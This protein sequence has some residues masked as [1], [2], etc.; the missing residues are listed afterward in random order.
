[1]SQKKEQYEEGQFGGIND[2]I[3]DKNYKYKEQNNKMI[4]ILFILIIAIIIIG[5]FFLFI[6][7]RKND[8]IIYDIK[9]NAEIVT[10]FFKDGYENKDFDKV[11]TYMVEN[12]YDHSPASARS[13]ADA[14]A[15]LKNVQNIFSDVKVEMLDLICEKDMVSARIWFKVT[16]TG[17][18]NGIPPSGKTITY[19]ALENFKVV[20]GKITES[21]G[22]WPDK[23]IEEKLRT[24]ETNETN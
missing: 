4:Y 2:N 6:T 9:K 20:N 10:S 22:Y 5:V 13:N 7:L 14:V 23:Q 3:L 15:I 18:Y 21:W 12:Y 8:E 11:M 1:M 24:N 16:H 19:E 17:E